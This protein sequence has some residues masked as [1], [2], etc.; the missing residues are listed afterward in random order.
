MT[1]DNLK[2]LFGPM[3]LPAAL[4]GFSSNAFQQWMPEAS[5]WIGWISLILLLVTTATGV[6]LIVT[7][8]VVPR[9]F[10]NLI[11]LFDDDRNLAVIEHPYH[12]RLQPPGSRLG[13]HEAPDQ[14]I[15]RVLRSE[16]GVN[17]QEVVTWPPIEE[18]YYGDVEIVPRPFQV[19]IERHQQ[20]LGIREHYD[21]VYAAR[22]GGKRPSLKSPLNPQWMSLSELRAV[23]EKDIKRA[24]F[25]DVI[26]TFEGMLRT[27]PA[28]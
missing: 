25:S 19:Q 11:Y 23:A 5:R 6:F 27:L 22:I 7:R 26:S 28:T 21:Y 3:V 12:N 18:R 20:R 2:D 17:P 24:P 10:A 9:R 14:A 8:R 13:Y 15:A 16:L 1:Q 4:V